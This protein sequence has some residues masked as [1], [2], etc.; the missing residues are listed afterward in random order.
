MVFKH[1]SEKKVA[2]LLSVSEELSQLNFYTL[3]SVASLNL[4]SET[5][6]KLFAD[7]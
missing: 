6:S 3:D 1:D 7:C 2:F 5:I 4:L